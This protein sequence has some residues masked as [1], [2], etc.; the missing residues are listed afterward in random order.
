MRCEDLDYPRNIKW[1]S[2][3]KMSKVEELNLE[4]VKIKDDNVSYHSNSI[5]FDQSSD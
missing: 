2:Y 5:I 4:I 3:V 1:L